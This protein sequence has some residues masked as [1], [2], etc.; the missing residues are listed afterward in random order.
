MD[1]WIKVEDRLPE[2]TELEVLVAY[3]GPGQHMGFMKASTLHHA[4]RPGGK[5]DVTHWMEAPVHPALQIDLS[6]IS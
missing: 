3:S 2:Y 6:L 1:N 5:T 4:M